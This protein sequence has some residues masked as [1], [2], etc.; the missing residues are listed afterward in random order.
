MIESKK[1]LIVLAGMVGLMAILYTLLRLIPPPK[2]YQASQDEISLLSINPVDVSS[3]QTQ[4][5]DERHIY[6]Q[7]DGQWYRD[8]EIADYNATDLRITYMSY[9]YSDNLVSDAA[10][11]LEP[12]GL[13]TPQAEASFET[14]SGECYTILF[15]IETVDQKSRYM[16]I[17]GSSAVYTIPIEAFEVIFQDEIEEDGNDEDT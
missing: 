14:F 4:W 5:N 6:T 9:L 15:G 3:A 10:Q 11:D 13:D 2:A 8:G 17:E 7:N 12:Y 1:G 16:M